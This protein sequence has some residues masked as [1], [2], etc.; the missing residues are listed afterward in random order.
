[1]KTMTQLV[2]NETAKV[3]E[4]RESESLAELKRHGLIEGETICLR[5]Q[6]PFGGDP[7]AIEVRGG[8]LAIRLSDAQ[9]IMVE[10]I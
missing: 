1:M 6:A 2:L 5:H 3:V 9:L 4:M 8:L 7:I 10:P